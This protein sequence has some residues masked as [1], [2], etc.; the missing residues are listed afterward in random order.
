MV[1]VG[2]DLVPPVPSPSLGS[3]LDFLHCGHTTFASGD[4]TTGEP[5]IGYSTPCITPPGLSRGERPPASTCWQ[6]EWPVG[7]PTVSPWLQQDC[8][9]ADEHR[10]LIHHVY[11]FCSVHAL[12]KGILE[13]W[14]TQRPGFF[15]WCCFGYRQILEVPLF[16]SCFLL[17]RQ[18]HPMPF[19]LSALSTPLSQD[20]W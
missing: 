3:S 11:S 20:C 2:R 17:L 14:E 15:R 18:H 4:H 19:C 6:Q 9:P 5:R 10:S 1:E 8:S 16:K 12:Q 7:H 13:S